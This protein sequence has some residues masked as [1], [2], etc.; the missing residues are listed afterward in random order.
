M[1]AHPREGQNDQCIEHYDDGQGAKKQF[2]LNPRKLTVLILQYWQKNIRV[3]I[4]ANPF[5]LQKK[6]EKNTLIKA[7]GKKISVNC[8]SYKLK[9]ESEQEHK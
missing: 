8:K 5:T 1:L 6:Q 9:K 2:P 7:S 3:L 4:R